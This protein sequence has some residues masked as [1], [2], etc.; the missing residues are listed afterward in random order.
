MTEVLDL[1]TVKC[2]DNVVAGKEFVA[3]KHVPISEFCRHQHPAIQ[4]QRWQQR[5]N[6]LVNRKTQNS[7][8]RNGV[9]R[10]GSQS[11]TLL[12]IICPLNQRDSERELLRSP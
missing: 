6:T 4:P 9:I 11:F 8:F 5:L 1:L 2:M 7:K 3:K 10:C 12:W